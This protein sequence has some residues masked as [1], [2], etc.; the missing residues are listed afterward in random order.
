M[1]DE[2]FIKVRVM[3]E[4]IYYVPEYVTCGYPSL[5]ALLNYWFKERPAYMCHATREGSVIER[6]FISHEIYEEGENET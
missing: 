1:T 3:V 4:E 6:K 5:E 2:K